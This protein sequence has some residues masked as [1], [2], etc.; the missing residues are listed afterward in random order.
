VGNA[1]AGG[2]DDA[3]TTALTGARRRL[4]TALRWR[5]CALRHCVRKLHNGMVGIDPPV[6]TSGRNRSDSAQPCGSA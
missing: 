5:L 6:E 2:V 4:A 1:V 3:C